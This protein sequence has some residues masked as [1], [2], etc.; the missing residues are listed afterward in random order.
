MTLGSYQV[1]LCNHDECSHSSEV[2]LDNSLS[3]VGYTSEQDLEQCTDY[4]LRIKPL[5]SSQDIQEKVV[6]FRTLSPAMDD[7]ASQLGPVTAASKTGQTVSVSWSGLKCAQEYQVYQQMV[8]SSGE[9]EEWEL[10]REGET[11]TE[12]SFTGV[13]CTEYRYGVRAVI[14]GAESDI[15]VSEETVVTPLEGEVFT[16]SNLDMKA[17]TESVA[18]SWDH[19]GCIHQ[20]RVRVCDGQEECQEEEVVM[21]GETSHAHVTI[22]SLQPCSEYTVQIFASTGDQE[23]GAET[24]RFSTQ[25]PEP[26][27]PENFNLDLN[28]KEAGVSLSFAPVTCARLY[29]VYSAGEGEEELLR[30]T[31]DTSVD[32]DSIEPCSDLR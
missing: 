20:Y 27:A 6:S 24:S 11:G 18:L 26:A 21:E 22:G 2:D 12:V 16:P 4:E 28:D 23:L 9:T 25:A 14:D 19:A 5:H 1:T 13:P 7:V 17:D 31:S 30:E 8:T 29:R 10:V 32:I 15:S 3:Y